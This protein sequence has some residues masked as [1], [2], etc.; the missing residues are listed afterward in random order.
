MSTLG[1]NPK[2]KLLGKD[3]E[4]GVPDSYVDSADL[5]FYFE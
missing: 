1:K 5:E 4:S 2:E 3:S